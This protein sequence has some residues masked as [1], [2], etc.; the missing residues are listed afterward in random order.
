ML[1]GH[2]R[3]PAVSFVS[4]VWG[5]SV[6]LLKK[7]TATTNKI[8]FSHFMCCHYYIN[9]FVQN[10]SKRHLTK[11]CLEMTKHTANI[12]KKQTNAPPSDKKRIVV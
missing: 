9:I 7:V 11:A 4:T 3:F 2:F 10:C 12:V 6:Y 5:H 1:A 8:F